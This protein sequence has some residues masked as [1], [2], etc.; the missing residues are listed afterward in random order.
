MTTLYGIKN[1][2][3]IKKA[4]K[5]LDSQELDYQFHDFREDGLDTKKVKAWVGKLGWES[6]VNK[7]SMTWKQLDDATKN[8]LNDENVVGVILESP[9]LIKRPLLEIADKYHTG[10]KPAEYE[11]LLLK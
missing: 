10:F 3:T 11:Q 9:T 4:R 2:D 5:W 6:L 7:R 1:C 8:S